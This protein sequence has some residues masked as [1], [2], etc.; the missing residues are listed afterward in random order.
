MGIITL[1]AKA[2]RSADNTVFQAQSFRSDH[3][4]IGRFARFATN[5]PQLIYRC[6]ANLIL[7]VIREN[8]LNVAKYLCAL[9]LWSDFLVA[10]EGLEPPT[11]GL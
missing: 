1:T 2:K 5:L 10:E 11:R 7:T 6:S 9:I 3:S 4:F 8:A